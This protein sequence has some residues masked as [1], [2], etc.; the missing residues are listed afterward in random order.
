SDLIYGVVIHEMTHASHYRMD[1]GFFLNVNFLTSDS[2]CKM[3]TLSESW[4][5]GVETIVTNDR[6]KQLSSNYVASA[7]MRD[8]DVGNFYNSI[9]Q[10]DFKNDIDEYTPIVTDLIDDY[11]QKEKLKFSNGDVNPNRPNDRVKGYNLNQIQSSL[12]T[13][14]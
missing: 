2:R 6:Y 13:S 5:E 8:N 14:R 12:N 10:E 4:A 7:I 1:K 11:N 3:Q 9:R